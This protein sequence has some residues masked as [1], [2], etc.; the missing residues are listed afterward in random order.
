MTDMNRKMAKGAS[1]LILFR[2]IDRGIG[3]VSTLILARL[4]IP[5]D[6]G[7]VAMAM[8]ILAFVSMLSAF[9]FDIA[10]IQNAQSERRHYD[11]AW[12]FNVFFGFFNALA[13]LALA[14]PVAAFYT[15]PRIVSIMAALAINCAIQG[16]GNI[17][18]VAFQK[19]LD[20]YKEFIFGLAKK[21]VAFVV[22]ISL[23]FSLRSYWALVAGIAASSTLGVLLSYRMHPYRPSFSLQGRE[24]L[25]HFSKWMLL[26]NFLISLAH[27]M[28][29]FVIG[30][31][32]GSEALGTYTVAYEIAN[33]PTTELVFPISRA[34]F[35]GYSKMANNGDELRNG[36]LDVL[37]VILLVTVP[38]GIGI[39]ILAEPIVHV[40]L[41]PKWLN[42]IP[43]IQVIGIFGILRA[44]SS[45]TGAV[46]VALG[47]PDLLTYLTVLSL[48]VMSLTLPW[49][50]IEY[51]LIGAA[52][53][54]L[55]AA[56]IQTPIGFFVV[57]KRINIRIEA[58]MSVM[59][60][61]IIAGA[62]MSGM[63]VAVRNKWIISDPI[64]DYSLQLLTLVPFG[65]A[66]YIIS[67][68]TLWIASG[69]CAGGESKL[70]S[71]ANIVFNFLL[72]KRQKLV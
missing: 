14:F 5:A 24:E 13:L 48:V 25:F 3:F 28:P 65:A 72:K 34:V 67:A 8:S 51:G 52:Y 32:V 7:L 50:V 16:F 38:A 63:I 33:M 53:S 37:S 15:E 56:A 69:R 64:T 18:V 35:P 54:V 44:S 46:Y 1:W 10:L 62:I 9:S 57:M 68:L 60:R 61:P 12:T 30:K 23:A 42:S 45:N 40:L 27:K 6:F 36:F 17:G 55:V 59:W 58:L 47:I 71:L 2:M 70:L 41:G 20:L 22:T 21:L 19:D 43:L 26:N 39:I 66:T 11:T 29:D 31:L 49:L 4:L